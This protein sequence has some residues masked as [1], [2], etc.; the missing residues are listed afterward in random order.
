[1]ATVCVG[2][3][4]LKVVSVHADVLMPATR[5]NTETL[6]N[7][8]KPFVG[9]GVLL[10][11]DLNAQPDEKAVE[12]LTRVGLHDLFAEKAS[13]AQPTFPSDKPRKRIDFFLVDEPLRA[14][15]GVPLV[16][17]GE[18]SDHRAIEVTIKL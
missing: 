5:A 11:G 14:Q 15:A 10:M 18:A 13:G 1:M 6:A 12:N 9:Q 8:L 7:Y 17:P 3:R 2:G 4:R 16:L